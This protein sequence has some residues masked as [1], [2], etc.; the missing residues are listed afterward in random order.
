MDSVDNKILESLKKR[1]RG[2][3]FTKDEYAHYAN[4][5][6]VQKAIEQ[7]VEKGLVIRVARGIYCYPKIDKV[8]NTGFLPPSCHRQERTG[9]DCPYRCACAQSVRLVRTAA[10]AVRVLN[11]RQDEERRTG[12]WSHV[13]VC[14]YRF[15]ESSVLQ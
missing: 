15:E 7:L 11:Q 10:Y 9:K 14:A 12:R 13:A 4:P 5:K 2:V 6:R 8:W 1:G 3:A